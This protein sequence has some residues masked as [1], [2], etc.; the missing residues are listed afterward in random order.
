MGVHTKQKLDQDWVEL[1]KEAKKL[2]LTI[3]EVYAFLHKE[4]K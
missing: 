4:S 3:E 2:G 1:I